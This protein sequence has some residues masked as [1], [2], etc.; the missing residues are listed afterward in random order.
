MW[1]GAWGIG[2][3]WEWVGLGRTWERVRPWC[4]RVLERP[5]EVGQ[6]P[7][8]G[9]DKGEEGGNWSDGAW[10]RCW[11]GA[12]AGPG[13]TGPFWGRGGWD[14]SRKGQARRRSGMGPGERTVEGSVGRME[15]CV[16]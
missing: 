14:P 9:R 16:P 4:S 5:G 13:R 3:A 7:E 8:R 15:E 1:G 6:G 10:P 11:E 12:W 2:V